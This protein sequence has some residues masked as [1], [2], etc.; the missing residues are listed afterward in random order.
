MDREGVDHVVEPLG[1][2]VAV[3]HGESLR[4]VRRRPEAT[5]WGRFFTAVGGVLLLAGCST[6]A[7]VVDGPVLSVGEDP[8]FVMLGGVGGTLKIDSRTGCLVFDET[9]TPIVWPAGATWQA[10]PPGVVLH[11]GHVVAVGQGVGA[12]GGTISADELPPYVGGDA[13]RAAAE[14]CAGPGGD[15][16][17]VQTAPRS[18]DA[19]P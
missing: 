6:P 7:G 18:P 15:I 5:T 19:A 17:L 2:G 10:E 11:D 8:E 9:R 1:P 14:R 16:V 4:T 3:V 13:I 12:G